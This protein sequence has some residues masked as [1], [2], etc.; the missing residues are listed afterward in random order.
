VD[1]YLVVRTTENIRWMNLTRYLKTRRTL[2]PAD[3]LRGEKLDAG[4]VWRVR[5][6]YIAPAVRSSSVGGSSPAPPEHPNFESCGIYPPLR[7]ASTGALGGAT[8]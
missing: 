1:V 7:G 8:D 5:D 2:E 3:R 6:E 4:A